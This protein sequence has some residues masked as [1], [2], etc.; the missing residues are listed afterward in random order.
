M[1]KTLLGL[2]LLA[3]ASFAADVY[4]KE[5]KTPHDVYMKEFKAAVAKNHMNVLY[6]LDLVEKFTNAGYAKKF[7]ADFNKNKLT[8][9]TTI[10]LCNGYIGNQVSNID[11]DAMAYCPIKVSVLSDARGTKVIYTKYAGQS[12]NQKINS[13]L[14]TLDTVVINTIDLTTNKYMNKAFSE[15]PSGTRHE[16]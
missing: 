3:C 14:K 13:L 15:D 12:K 4:K 2:M 1:K 9:A 16:Q 11:P 5:V 10:L 7:G 8:G 6:E